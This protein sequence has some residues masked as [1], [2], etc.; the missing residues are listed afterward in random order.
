VLAAASVSDATV[1]LDSATA[2]GSQLQAEN[3]KYAEV[4]AV[5]AAA[6]A[7]EAMLTQAMGEEIRYSQ[8][9]NDLS[10]TV[11]EKVWLKNVTFTQVAT[12]PALGAT[13]P[14]L[15][16]VTFTGVSYS[17]NDVAVW[18]ESLAKQQGYKDPYFSASTEVLIGKR[19]A[20]DFSSTV[21]L[22]PTPCRSS[23]PPRPEA[24]MDKLK[25]W[26]VLTVVGLLAVLAAAGSSASRRSRPRRTTWSPRRSPRSRPTTGSHA[27]S[28]AQGPPGQ[29]LPKKQADP[30]SRRRRRSRTT[31]PCRLS[32]A[33]LD[34]GRR[35]RA[36]VVL[37]SITPCP[38]TGRAVLARAHRS[39]RR[40]RRRA[41]ASR[42]VGR[43]LPPC[44]PA[45]P[46]VPAAAVPRWIRGP[47]RWLSSGGNQPWSAA[48]IFSGSVAQFLANLEKLPRALRLT[49]RDAQPGH[50]SA[51]STS[52]AA[53]HAGRALADHHHHRL[54]VPAANRPPAAA[55]VAP[56]G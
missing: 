36:G 24:D 18:L 49:H 2:T 35:R 7:A 14:G 52:G 54:G 15:G 13:E 6:A 31:R 34:L 12:P 32:S 47:E 40:R 23:T 11:P 30:G 1:E 46:V 29:D 28:G 25:Q 9:L 38:R 20:V 21:A 37:V 55:V 39:R 17:H 4:T 3:A 51:A 44:C 42:S 50:L 41:P 8:F 10:L 16:T 5:Y 33:T 26:V 48:L 19:K 45:A 27:A 53:R 43:L 56:V 22:T